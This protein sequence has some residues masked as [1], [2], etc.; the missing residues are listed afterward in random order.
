MGIMLMLRAP[1]LAVLLGAKD[2]AGLMPLNE[3]AA[4]C[5]SSARTRR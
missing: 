3:N 2:T 1:D 5:A 4:A